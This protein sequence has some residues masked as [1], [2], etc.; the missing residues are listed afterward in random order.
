MILG[1]AIIEDIIII[2]ILAVLQSI[3]STGTLSIVEIGL[4]VVLVLAFTEGTIFLGART[5]QVH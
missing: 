1:V 4:S 5:V 2:P 3:A